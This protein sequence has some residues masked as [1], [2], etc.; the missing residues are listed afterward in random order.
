MKG[1]L[2]DTGDEIIQ[3]KPHADGVVAHMSET[4][5][6]LDIGDLTYQNCYPV[7]SSYEELLNSVSCVQIKDVTGIVV[8]RPHTFTDDDETYEGY[9]YSVIIKDG[10]NTMSLNAVSK[11]STLYY[12]EH[13]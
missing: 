6:E 4:P 10:T 5:V 3:R 1:Y 2:Y 13:G 7:D 11:D 8:Y 9:P 12:I